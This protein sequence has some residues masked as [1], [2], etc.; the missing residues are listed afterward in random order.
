MINQAC[1]LYNENKYE[2]AYHMLNNVEDKNKTPFAYFI[3]A[4]I[5]SDYERPLD[6]IF[7]L[8]K[9]IQLDKKYYKAYYNL[10]NL[11]ADNNQINNA[12]V[13]YKNAIKYKSDF[14]YAY[15]NLGNAYFKSGNLNG[16]K[17]AY[18]AAISHEKKNPG[19]L[20]QSFIY[21]QKIER[22]KKS[23]KNI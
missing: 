5:L 1:V 18:L 13:C 6:A 17:K 15:F 12:I 3:M 7:S 11:Y 14:S 4:N 20:L 19:I 23:T 22:F 16:A 10:G 2:L 21:I 8:Q 9:A